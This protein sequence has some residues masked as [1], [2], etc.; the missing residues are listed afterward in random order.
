MND[1][2][3]TICEQFISDRDIV[4]STFPWDSSYIIPLCAMSLGSRNV[5]VT[6]DKL[7]AC[8]KALEQHTS[9]FSNF[10]GNTKLPMVTI[11]AGADDPLDKMQAAM[12]IYGEM[13][14][15]FYGSE[16]LAYISAVLTDMV[17]REESVAVAQRSKELY[18][19]M[20]KEHP[21]LTSSEDSGYAVLLSFSEKSNDELIAD[22]EQ[23]YKLLKQHFHNSNPVQSVSHV[24]TLGKGSSEEKC[25]RL[26]AL[27]KGLEK[28]GL[29]YSTYYELAAL[30]SLSIL[31]A[32]MNTLIEEIRE[33]DEF[34][35]EQKGYGL[36]TI[37]RTT[38]LMHAVVLVSNSYMPDA[39]TTTAAMNGTLAIVAAQQAAMCAIIACGASASSAAS[40]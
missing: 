27:F 32:E 26:V 20:K 31:D 6:A 24:L 4:K 34:L 22:M 18:N 36:F 3:K 38:R 28:A 40:H 35:S 7:K 37:D 29:R 39:V 17:T 9:I 14:E 10:R 30:A 1:K 21:F 2:L 23:C 5:E 33:V 16:Y 19:R 13:R 15:V 11:L 25:E 8:R 12:A